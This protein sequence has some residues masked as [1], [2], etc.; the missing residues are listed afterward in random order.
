LAIVLRIA[1]CRQQPTAISMNRQIV[2][3]FFDIGDT[4]GTVAGKSLK[5]FPDTKTMLA[6]MKAI[7]LQLG[8]M[9]NI[10]SNWDQSD[11]VGLL[12]KARILSYFE[13]NGI[14][15]STEAHSSKPDRSFFEFGA[16][17]LGISTDASLFVGESPAE[18]AR[19]M[20]LINSA[21][22]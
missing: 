2:A 19:M 3:V 14:I 7:G 18:V 9:T 22:E 17:Q 11:V 12:D 21:G 16:A 10:P 15:T 6:G 4:L 1:A 20:M 5:L 13:R 8:V